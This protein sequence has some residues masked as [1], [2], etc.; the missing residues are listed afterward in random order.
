MKKITSFELPVDRKIAGK[1]QII[2][3][4]GSGWEGEVYKVIE[5]S[6][7]IERAAKLFF[8]HRNLKDK[9]SKTYAIKLHKLRYCSLLIQYHTKETIIYQKTPVTVLISEYVDGIPLHEFLKL[10]VGK[11]LDPYQGIHLLYALAKGIEEIH[12]LNEYHGDLHTENIIVNKFGLNFD[13]KILDLFSFPASK[14]ENTRD[15][16]CSLIQIFYECIGGSKRYSAQP[17]VIKNI[18]CGLKRSLIL[19]KFRTV[20][21]L[22]E[23]LETMDCMEI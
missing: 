2:S 15:D 12:L 3:K 22:R 9:A 6:T 20:S 10:M 19:K 11:R 1:Y 23:H 14:K 5:L 13:L 17:Q 18:C 7:G 8:P 16:I 21:H 4:L